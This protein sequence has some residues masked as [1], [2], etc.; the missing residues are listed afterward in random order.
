MVDNN[1]GA[2]ARQMAQKADVTTAKKDSTTNARLQHMGKQ[3]AQGSV[4][5]AFKALFNSGIAGT[6]IEPTD[7]TPREITWPG[8]SAGYAGDVEIPITYTDF[9]N[10]VP[11]GQYQENATVHYEGEVPKEK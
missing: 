2:M 7:S 11:I 10:G 1:V 6:P 4:A 8:M 5:G 3:V 9:E